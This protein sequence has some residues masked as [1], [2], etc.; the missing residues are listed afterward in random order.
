MC[1]TLTLFLHVVIG[2]NTVLPEFIVCIS[3]LVC[4]QFG[5]ENLYNPYEYEKVYL[6]CFTHI[7]THKKCKL[8]QDL[9]KYSV[10]IN[11][12]AYKTRHYY[13]NL[14]CGTRLVS[15]FHSNMVCIYICALQNVA[16]R[17]PPKNK[18]SGKC[19][20]IMSHPCFLHEEY[21]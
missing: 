2:R 19:S 9:M 7:R 14:S 18:T 15:Y 11:I 16:E 13:H 21:I 17:I 8:Q 1:T 20:G 12:E 5:D 6:Q 10:G 4:F 3:H